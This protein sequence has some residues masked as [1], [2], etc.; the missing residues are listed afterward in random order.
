MSSDVEVATA[1][2]I[3]GGEE[4]GVPLADAQL[5]QFSQYSA[6]LI[7]WNQRFNLTAITDP[8]DIFVRHFLDSLTCLLVI[9]PAERAKSLRVLDIGSGAGFP[10][11]ALAIAFPHWDV[12]LLEATGK[13]VR[14]LQAVIEETGISH[15]HALAG[16]AEEFAHQ[17]AYRGRFQIVTARAVAALPVLLEYGLPFTARGGLLIAPKKGDITAEVEAGTRAAAVLGAQLATPVPVTLPEL[18][19]GRV[20]VSAK[21]QHAIASQYPRAGGAPVRRP[22]GSP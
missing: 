2:L 21:L 11:L 20:I 6:M 13:K 16:R 19:D 9:P 17:P 22:L 15:A 3:R 12:T 4:L 5:R 14:F 10:G 8:G 1:A 18:S 7:E